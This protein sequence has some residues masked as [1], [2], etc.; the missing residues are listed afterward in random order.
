MGGTYDDGA[1]GSSLNG[2]FVQASSSLYMPTYGVSLNSTRGRRSG[3]EYGEWENDCWKSRADCLRT[4]DLVKDAC[5]E[6]IPD[7]SIAV[8]VV[9]IIIGTIVTVITGGT[10]TPAVA[11]VI[12]GSVGVGGVV[13]GAVLEA[14]SAADCNRIWNRLISDCEREYQECLRDPGWEERRHAVKARLNCEERCRKKSFIGPFGQFSAAAYAECVAKW[15]SG[16]IAFPG[17]IR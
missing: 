9:V 14:H 1:R 17:R 6:A 8:V 12:V 10:A 5:M 15:C 2:I 16:N 13:G 3:K 11:A 7:E 4:A